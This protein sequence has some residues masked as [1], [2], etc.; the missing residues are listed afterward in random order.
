MNMGALWNII[1]IIFVLQNVVPRIVPRCFDAFDW[2]SEMYCCSSVHNS[3]RF[4]G[5]Q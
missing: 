1:G 5:D 3:G 2:A 4:L